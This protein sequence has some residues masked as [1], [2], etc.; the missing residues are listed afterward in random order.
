MV[1]GA[2]T[3]LGRQ[4][5]GVGDVGQVQRLALVS[6][7]SACAR[8]PAKAEE[9]RADEARH[10]IAGK[11]FAYSCFDGTTGNGRIYADGSVAGYIQRRRQRTAALRGAA[12]RHAADQRRPLLR[13]AARHSVRALLQPRAHQPGQLP[14]LDLGLRLC[15]LRFRS[16]QRR[17]RRALQPRRPAA[18]RLP[19]LGSR[20]THSMRVVTSPS[21][22]SAQ[23]ITV[24]L[25]RNSSTAGS[26]AAGLLAPMHR[27]RDDASQWSLKPTDSA[28]CPPAARRRS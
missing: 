28:D 11:H 26:T 17:A 19:R 16:R 3:A 22:T 10:F 27:G 25:L 18:P 24:L 2:L 9:M 5:S 13:L 12:D 8:C 14:R 21:V 20:T 15:L 4:A 7:R 1:T 23:C 6:G